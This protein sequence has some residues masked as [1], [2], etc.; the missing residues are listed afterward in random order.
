MGIRHCILPNLGSTESWLTK[1][2][3][4]L[5]SGH[6]GNQTVFTQLS[7]LYAWIQGT[8]ILAEQ[9]MVNIK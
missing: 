4:D 7:G 3:E 8:G 5:M 2:N 6:T 9:S 1:E